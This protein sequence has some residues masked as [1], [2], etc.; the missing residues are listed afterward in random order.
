MNHFFQLNEILDYIRRIIFTKCMSSV[1]RVLMRYKPA[2]WIT[3][4]INNVSITANMN[5][6]GLITLFMSGEI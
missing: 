5:M 2:P 6:A 4:N 1:K 3:T